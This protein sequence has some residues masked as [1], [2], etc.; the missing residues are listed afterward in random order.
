MNFPTPKRPSNSLG[1]VVGK[2]VQ[3]ASL[4]IVLILMLMHCAVA[5]A[6]PLSVVASAS[7]LAALATAIGGEW[8]QVTTLARPDQ[9]PHSFEVRPMHVL[10]VRH[11]DVYLKVGVGLDYW[12]DDVIRAAANEQLRVT[13]CSRGISLLRDADADLHGHGEHAAGNPHY[14][15]GP[16]NVPL[17]A[18]NIADGLGEADPEHASEF[19]SSLTLFVHAFDSARGVWQERMARCEGVHLVTYHQSWDY[20][21][22]EFHLVI[23]GTVEPHPGVEPSPVQLALLE[24]VIRS[25]KAEMLLMEPF[26]SDRIAT[27]LGE[28]TGI[29]TI[30]APPSVGTDP[31]VPDIFSLF[32][33]LT[34]ELSEHC[35][36][37]RL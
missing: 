32:D 12:S 2:T 34:R 3:I 17:M 19:S 33:F 22:R 1:V 30:K 21:S 16:S 20:F 23:V 11:A 24:K 36:E 27:L 25:D 35:A 5:A 26:E 9:D 29:M 15:L 14:W 31:A 28:D 37:S 6:R 13:D 18:R 10:A 8:V 7:D 4:S